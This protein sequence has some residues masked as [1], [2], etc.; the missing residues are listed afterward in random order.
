MLKQDKKY[1]L[2]YLVERPAILRPEHLSAE[3]D[4]S[5]QIRR[6]ALKNVAFDLI[7]KVREEKRR[8]KLTTILSMFRDK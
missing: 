4:K 2:D 8:P 1:P 6:N 3:Q 5:K 7:L